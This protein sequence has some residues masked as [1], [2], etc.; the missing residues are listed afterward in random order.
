M[1]F[2]KKVF[3]RKIDDS[4]HRQFVRFGKGIYKNR[5]VIKLQKGKEIKISSTFEYANDFVDIISMSVSDMNVSGIILSKE[6]I[7]NKHLKNEKLKA[8]IYNY[9]IDGNVSSSELKDILHKSYFV[10]ADIKTEGIEFKCKKKLPKPGKGGEGKSDDKFCVLKADLKY[11]PKIKES[12]FSDVPENVKKCKAKHIFDIQKIIQPE[13]EKDY[14][15]VRLLSKR[16]GK[17]TRTL[18]IDKKQEMRECEFEA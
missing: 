2:I 8:G 3:E 13:G 5:A 6:K 7:D 10:L 15:K 18:E 1:N 17:I 9:D 11:W 14:E 4:V 12:F 16:A